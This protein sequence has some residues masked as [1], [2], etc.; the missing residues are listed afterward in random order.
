MLCV[1]AFAASRLLSGESIYRHVDWPVVI[2]LA[3][4]IPIGNTLNEYGISSAIAE[5][6]TSYSSFLNLYGL[7]IILMIITMFLSDIINN[8]ALSLTDS[9]GLKN[10]AFP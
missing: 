5:K 9:P 4:M 7:L 3:V 8:A 6:I 10:S 2:L 1:L